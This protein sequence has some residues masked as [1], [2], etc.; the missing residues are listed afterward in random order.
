MF[1]DFR[2]KRVLVVGMARSGVAVAELLTSIGAR[3]VLSDLRPDIDSLPTLEAM[4]CEARLG[5]PSESLVAGCVAVIVSPGIRP[6]APVIAEAE[7]LGIPVWAELEFATRFTK[8]LQ[9]AITGTNG[10][11]TTASLVGEILKNAGKI[12]YVAGN[13]GLPLSAVATQTTD[14]DFTV[15]EVSSFQLE[16][17]EMFHPHGAALLNLTPD[18]LNRHGTMEAYGAL[19]E[20]MLQNQTRHDF[21]VYNAEDAFCVEVAGRAT[22]KTIPFSRLKTLRHGAWVQDGQLMLEGRALCA[23]SDVMLPGPHNLENALAAAAIASQLQIPPAVIRHTLRSFSGVPHRM[24]TVRTLHGVRWINDSKGTNP[25]SSTRGVEGMAVPTV[26]IAGGDDKGSDFSVL[27]EAV[28]HNPNIRHA[29]LIGKTAD[30]LRE[31]LAAHG[32]TDVTMAGFDFEAAVLTARDLADVGGAVLLS[33][34]CASFDMFQDFEA[35]GDR[36]KEIV[37]ALP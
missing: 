35:R 2:G 5:E 15:V 17:I 11:T 36:F 6:D 32:F 37:K 23:T 13:I 7:R 27:A 1:E 22:A 9:V 29:V 16:H 31:A 14:D 12:T 34:G 10:K 3:P 28:A 20:G 30:L 24:E 26:L 4:G 18:H 8:G 19:K 33:P 21:F 25:E